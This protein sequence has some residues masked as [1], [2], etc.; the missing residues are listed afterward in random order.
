MLAPCYRPFPAG[1]SHPLVERSPLPCSSVEIVSAAEP[2]DCFRIEKPASYSCS[3]LQQ[4]IYGEYTHSSFWCAMAG[5]R[6]VDRNWDASTGSGVVGYN[7]YRGS[8]VGR[9][10]LEDYLCAGRQHRPHGDP[11]AKVKE[12]FPLLFWQSLP[13]SYFSEDLMP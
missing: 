7:V 6:R 9:L 12:R 13:D 8:V 2:P 3:N 11:I 4:C 5:R 1:R 10:V